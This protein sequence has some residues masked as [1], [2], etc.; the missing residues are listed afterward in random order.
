MRQSAGILTAGHLTSHSPHEDW[1]GLAVVARA[2]GTETRELKDRQLSI[3]GIKVEVTA[4][5]IHPNYINL[6]N[7]IQRGVVQTRDVQG[8]GTASLSAANRRPPPACRHC[9]AKD[10]EE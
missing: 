8:R 1:W 10:S 5:T 3:R 2:Q 7:H 4:Y 6:A 9:S